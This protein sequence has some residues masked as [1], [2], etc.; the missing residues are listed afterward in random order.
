[1]LDTLISRIT[2]T[3]VRAGALV[4]D[5]AQGEPAAPFLDLQ[6]DGPLDELVAAALRYRIVLGPL[7]GRKT[8][9]LQD[10]ALALNTLPSKPFTVSRDGF[11]LNA[12]VACAADERRKLERVCRYLLRPAISLERLS[13]D[14][15]GLVVYQLKRPFSNGTTHVLFEPLDFIARLAALVPRPRSHLLR[16]HGLFAPNA[17]HR[18]LIV[19]CPPAHTAA[20]PAEH[21]SPTPPARLTWMARLHRVFG[22]D[23]ETCPKC[24]A[25]LRVI[26]EVT[27]P[28][29]IARILEHLEHR[30]RHQRHPRA[31][32]MTPTDSHPHHLGTFQL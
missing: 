13:I 8:M 30:E 21:D 27:A 23:I 5:S 29:V 16:Y 12:A 9:T 20:K 2:R 24:G 15:D 1:L 18:R 31:P 3:L 10:P 11:S 19:P 26:G 6:P 4:E 22:I 25:K 17:R 14:G 32:P 28:A 7:A